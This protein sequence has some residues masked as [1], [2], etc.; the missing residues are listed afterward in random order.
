MYHYRQAGAEAD[1]DVM[2][3]AKNVQA[4]LSKCTDAKRQ[5]DWNTLLIESDFAISA[6]AD[7]APQV[8]PKIIYKCI[9][10]MRCLFLLKI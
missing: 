6:G 8:S 3:K 2:S 10:F 5:R 4:H 9:V 7:S 1:P